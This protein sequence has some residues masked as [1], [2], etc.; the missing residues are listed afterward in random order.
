[1][2]TT[3]STP[4][5]RGQELPTS[6]PPCA[7]NFG[8]ALGHLAMVGPKSSEDEVGSAFDQANQ[9]FIESIEGTK[10][11]SEGDCTNCLEGKGIN[12][13]LKETPVELSNTLRELRKLSAVPARRIKKVLNNGGTPGI[14]PIDQSLAN[15]LNKLGFRQEISREIPAPT[16]DTPTE[17][18]PD[19]RGPEVREQAIIEEFKEGRPNCASLL[20][21]FIKE[22]NE[23][24]GRWRKRNLG[25]PRSE[26]SEFKGNESLKLYSS[27][28]DAAETVDPANC[29]TCL[30][31]YCPLKNDVGAIEFYE[32]TRAEITL[33]D[34]SRAKLL[35]R[36]K[37]ILDG[38]PWSKLMGPPDPTYV[39]IGIIETLRAL[40][41]KREPEEDF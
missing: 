5:G 26:W 30:D 29:S 1:M 38:L 6:R 39:T 23:A 17:I 37:N 14:T 12:C 7:T 35:P 2:D 41:K 36:I 34:G 25:K 3:P 9:F 28:I 32:T 10:R 15:E 4:P 27:A 19:P 33:T 16:I 20:S 40:A 24:R 11:K 22:R 18:V 8:L 31:E 13:P 21:Q